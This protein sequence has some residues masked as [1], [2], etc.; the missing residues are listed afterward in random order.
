MVQFS[1][2]AALLSSASLALGQFCEHQWEGAF[3]ETEV[4]GVPYR[5]AFDTL[6][7]PAIDIQPLIVTGPSENR[8]DLLFM[9]DGCASSLILA[10]GG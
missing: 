1:K 10:D 6:A 4:D 7:A 3:A 5:L 9:G 2:S 8:V